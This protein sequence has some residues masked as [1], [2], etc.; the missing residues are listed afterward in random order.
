MPTVHFVLFDFLFFHLHMRGAASEEDAHKM[1]R[2][3]RAG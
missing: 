1:K 3:Y 2:P